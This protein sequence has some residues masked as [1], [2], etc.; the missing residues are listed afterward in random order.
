MAYVSWNDGMSVNVAVID[1]QHQG[2]IDLINQLHQ[3]MSQGQ[4]NLVLREIVDGLLEYTALHFETEERHFRASEYPD[5]ATHEKEHREFVTKVTDFKQG[6]AEGRLML[7]LD[8]MDFLGDWL[9]N[10]IQGSDAAYAP[11]LEGASQ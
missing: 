9:I 11:F 8:V 5:S 1:R 2:L 10:H 7:T 3:A 6:F 4:G